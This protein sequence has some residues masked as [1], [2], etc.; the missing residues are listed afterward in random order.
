MNAFDAMVDGGRL[1]FT[2]RSF[3]DMNEA[4]EYLRI[5]VAD[6]GK[7]IEPEDLDRIFERYFTTKET[8]TGL[9]LAVVER[10]IMAHNGKVAA[11]SMTG[12]GT[13]FFIDLPV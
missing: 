6:T 3:R 5:E 13:S 11:E 12:K 10:I 7:G 1:T 4:R 2:V 8:G 9:G